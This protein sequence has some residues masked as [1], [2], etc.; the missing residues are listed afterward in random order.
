MIDNCIHLVVIP[1][2]G[3][4]IYQQIAKLIFWC[5]KNVEGKWS[6][7]R[8]NGDTKETCYWFELKSDAMAF[9]LTWM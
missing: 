4:S 1:D 2:Q 8:Y 7:D 6:R 9:K 5:D 3:G